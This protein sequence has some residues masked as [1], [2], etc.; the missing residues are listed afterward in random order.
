MRP[1]DGTDAQHRPAGAGRSA[2][3]SE[4]HCCAGGLAGPRLKQKPGE[5]TA[6]TYNSTPSPTAGGRT[7]EQSGRI[8]RNQD[9]ATLPVLR[10]L[11]VE[12]NVT[13]AGESLGL[14]Q[15][16]TSAVLA[17]LR[18]RFGDQLLIRVGRDYELT[19]LAASLLSRI[20]SA[21]EALERVFGDDFD[22]ATTNRQFSLALSRPRGEAQHRAFCPR[23]GRGQ[24]DGRVCNSSR[25]CA[26]DGLRLR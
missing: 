20:E 11:L 16:A 10:A 23:L 13:R 17:R 12:R 3:A 14:S 26:T 21:T 24:S 2:K 15:P 1:I 8:L 22:P 4:P 25:I 18:R 6:V 7:P 5:D 9:V 19:P